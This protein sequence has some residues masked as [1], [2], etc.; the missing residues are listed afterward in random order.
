VR[1][2]R[3]I[4]PLAIGLLTLTLVVA[5]PLHAQWRVAPRFEG[6]DAGLQVRTANLQRPALDPTPDPASGLDQ[7]RDLVPSLDFDYE[8][9]SESA[10]GFGI[11][12]IAASTG[13]LVGLI[14]GAGVTGF[15][16]FGEN[17]CC[18]NN[19][20]PGIVIVSALLGSTLGSTYGAAI[21]GRHPLGRALTGSLVGVGTGLLMMPRGKNFGGEVLGQFVTYSL[22]QGLT[23]AAITSLLR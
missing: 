20:D 18:A 9:R 23:T 12:F 22:T 8:V 19:E 16:V 2:F 21:I 6:L 14:A 17:I 7:T 15:P 3:S 5:P 10:R 1:G 4:G 11:T 13:S